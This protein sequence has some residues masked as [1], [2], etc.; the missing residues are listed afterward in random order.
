MLGIIRRGRSNPNKI[1]NEVGYY[2][3][4]I[5]HR[6]LRQFVT[7]DEVFYFL[8]FPDTCMIETLDSRD[9]IDACSPSSLFYENDAAKVF[10]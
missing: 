4:A 1:Y 10:M 7:E 6:L 9:L 2:W 3:S 8:Y 5:A